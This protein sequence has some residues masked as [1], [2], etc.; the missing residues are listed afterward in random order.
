V[1]NAKFARV[2]LYVYEKTPTNVPKGVEVMQASELFPWPSFQAHLVNGAKVAVLADYVRLLGIQNVFAEGW[3]YAWFVDLDVIWLR[4]VKAALCQL[5]ATAFEHV[6]GSMQGL[7]HSRAGRKDAC[8]KGMLEFLVEPFDFRYF[9]TP[10]RI[11]SRSRVVPLML[12]KLK[13][14][15]DASAEDYNVAMYKFQDVYRQEGLF[16]AILDPAVF[17]I[18][19][20]HTKARVLFGICW[21]LLG[22]S[23]LEFGSCDC[24]A[25]LFLLP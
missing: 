17:C 10:L 13:G 22:N 8:K 12:A 14:L 6:A 7:A 2:L 25:I 24:V 1:R 4:E 5:D 3:V 21:R 18:V 9:S 11:T 16:G 20:P 19:A 23:W 15:L